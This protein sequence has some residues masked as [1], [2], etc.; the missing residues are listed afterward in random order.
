LVRQTRQHA[1]KGHCVRSCTGGGAI[2]FGAAN[3]AS[4]ETT[5]TYRTVTK[6]KNAWAIRDVWRTRYEHRVHRVV[7][8]TLVKPVVRVHVVDRFHYRTVALVR[9]ENVRVMRVL[10]TRFV[11][12][13]D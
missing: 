12:V 1:E 2:F 7:H 13:R 11:Y 3:S 6:V 5:Y 8:V 9:H 10:P 4:A